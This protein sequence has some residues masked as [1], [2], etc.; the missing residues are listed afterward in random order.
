MEWRRNP[1]SDANT[2]GH[3][4]HS[5]SR[6][7]NNPVQPT[8]RSAVV[9]PSSQFHTYALVWTSSG[10][11]FSVDGVDTATMTPTTAEASAFQQEFFLILNLSLGARD[12]GNTISLL[13]TYE[14]YEVDK[15]HC[16]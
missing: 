2:V 8:S 10:M 4:L 3:A 14:T 16:Y 15:V 6:N 12:L 1:T 5:S 11:T 9:N 7:G 13:V